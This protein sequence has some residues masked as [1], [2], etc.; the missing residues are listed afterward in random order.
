ME[1]PKINLHTHTLFSDGKNSIKQIVNKSIKLGLNYLAI[2]DHFTNSW[3]AGV[4]STTL[5]TLEKID[6]YLNEITEC[7]EFLT[8]NN[9]NLKL[10]KG[11]EVDIGSSSAYIK[12]LIRPTEFDLIL[13]EY[14]ETPEG[15]AFV[16][17]IIDQWKK[18][19]VFNRSFPLFG[20]AHFDPSNFIYGSLNILMQFLKEYDIYVEFNSSYPQFYSWRNELF[21]KKL[22]EY[23]IM[24][25][26]GSDAHTSRDLD[27]MFNPLEMI[28]VYKLENNLEI[29]INH[30]KQ[31][32]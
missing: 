17:N 9:K 30:L 23:N 6:H 27:N 15:I 25:T 10:Y 4:I 14:L 2:T 20:L 7:Q 16:K 21:F 18:T 22:K 26:I 8:L 12:R 24:V 5:N 3:K 13:F 19:I 29:F 11:I 1:F 31:K 28:K 32:T